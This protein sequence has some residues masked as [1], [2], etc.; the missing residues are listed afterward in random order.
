MIPVSVQHK[1]LVWLSTGSLLILFS[2][3]LL[4]KASEPVWRWTLPAGVSAPPIPADNPMT[5]AKVELGRRLFYDADLSADGTMSCATC[6]EQKHAFADGNRTHPG[7]TDEPARRN[8]PGLAN[9]AWFTPLTFADPANTTLEAQA[10]TPVF[11]IRPVEMGMAGREAEI[12]VRLGRDSCY[13]AMF[14]RAFPENGGR[15]DFANVARALA[16]FERTLV[17]HGSAWDRQQLSPDAKVGSTLFARD[18]AACHSGPH[19]T[20]S[21]MHRLE[22]ADP[23]FADQG[24]FEKTGIDADRGR[25][26]TPS[27]RNVTLTGPWWH[28]GSARSL[29][30]AIARHGLTH[31]PAETNHLIAFLESL[32]DPEF[33]R[34]KSLAMPGE[35]CGRPL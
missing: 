24:L 2:A 25:F 22:A 17:S 33:I 30:D 27:L 21:A 12:G 1:L 14:A 35:A 23:T 9:V 13:Q 32:S 5:A 19:F 15:I 3:G 7:V 28:D 10:A 4:S 11:G 26:R 20:D 6:H 29:A 16:S 18:C 8:V 31:E 34:R